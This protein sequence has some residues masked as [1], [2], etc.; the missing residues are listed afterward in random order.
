M[1]VQISLIIIPT[2]EIEQKWHGQKLFHKACK[3]RVI[4]MCD[5]G[6]TTRMPKKESFVCA[7]GVNY[8]YAKSCNTISEILLNGPNIIVPF[9]SVWGFIFWSKLR[10][11]LGFYQFLG[12]VYLFIIWEKQLLSW[13]KQNYL[14]FIYFFRMRIL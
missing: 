5:R 13:V 14:Y 9:F 8:S 3:K 4:C 10:S 12:C 2:I 1:T 11:K 6:K 7:T